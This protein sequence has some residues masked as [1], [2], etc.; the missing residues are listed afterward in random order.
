MESTTLDQAVESLL[1][2][3]TE[4]TSGDNLSEAV[5]QI[6]EPEDDGQG[7]EIEAVAESDDDAE[8]E[9][10]SEQDDEEYDLDDVE[11]DDED[12]VEAQA[13]DTKLI[14]VKVDGKEEHWT[15][16]QL[17]QSAAGQAAINKRFQEASE[18]RKQNEH[19]RAE[20]QQRQKQFVHSVQQS[21]QNGFQAPNPPS[22]ELIESDPI[23]YMEEK[24]KYD[25][26]KAQYD[27]NMFQLQ[28]MHRQNM[29]AQQ[30]AHQAYL[31]EQAQVLQEYIP[32]IVDPKKGQGLKDALVETGVSYGF[33]AEE[34]QA[35][36]DARYVRA[37]NDA[38]KYRELVAKKKSGQTKANKA[39][40][41]VKA[42][43]KKRQV[44]NDANRK[45]A[46][47]RLQKT[48]S[49]DDALNLIIGNS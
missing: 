43:A 34:M 33:S 29:Q 18:V 26:A 44:G 1:S 13:E 49:I 4:D 14:T 45:K 20:L 48:G 46:Q 12:P 36:T 32:E 23:G 17:K 10:S 8:V 31:Q 15:L 7:E 35:V 16:D 41:V 25:E 11:V 47:Q 30:A 2:P 3:A 42:G 5:D 27:Q 21:Q 37:L 9:A 39:S 19:D 38:R 22:R 28:G 6:T 24:L 40:P